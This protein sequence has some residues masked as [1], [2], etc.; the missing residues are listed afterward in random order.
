MIDITNAEIGLYSISTLFS[1]LY[2]K[3]VLFNGNG[4]K[5]HEKQTTENSKLI[6]EFKSDAKDWM[7]RN[8]GIHIN[9]NLRALIAKQDSII[10]DLDSIKV[11]LVRHGNSISHINDSNYKYSLPNIVEILE[12]KQ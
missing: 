4:Q 8:D 6:K 9:A 5:N 7:D 10:E 11:E 1:L 2:I 3:N 12:E